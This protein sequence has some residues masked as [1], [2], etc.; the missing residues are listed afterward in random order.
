MTA[1][2]ASC[3]RFL[4]LGGGKDP[5]AKR[6][7]IENGGFLAAR[8]HSDVNLLEVNKLGGDLGDLGVTAT[9][10]VG[11]AEERSQ[12]MGLVLNDHVREKQP[13]EDVIRASVPRRTGCSQLARTCRSWGPGTKQREHWG[14]F[15]DLTFAGGFVRSSTARDL[16]NAIAKIHS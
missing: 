3:P 5:E 8:L 7:G 15:G 2:S 6:I 14:R 13:N 9:G 1:P 12:F 16:V 11:I 4:L 10:E